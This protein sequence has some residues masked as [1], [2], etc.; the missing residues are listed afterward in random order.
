MLCNTV[1]MYHFFN[2]SF[3]HGIACIHK[4]TAIVYLYDTWD[5]IKAFKTRQQHINKDT[6]LV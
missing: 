2:N 5:Y 3:I 1:T 6:M 4:L